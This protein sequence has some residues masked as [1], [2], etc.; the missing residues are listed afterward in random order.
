MQNNYELLIT[1][2]FTLCASLKKGS[3]P[4]FHASMKNTQSFGFFE[5]IVEM[6]R[7][8][9]NAEKIQTGSF[10]AD[11]DVRLSNDGPVTIMMDSKDWNIDDVKVLACT[12]TAKT[13]VSLKLQNDL[14]NF[15]ISPSKENENPD[16]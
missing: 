14:N 3:K 7:L 16:N 9:Y 15:D 10:G 11:M 4:D 5:E 1:S 2:Q 8:E 6:F 13:N 12:Q